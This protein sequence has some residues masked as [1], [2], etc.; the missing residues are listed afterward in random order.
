MLLFEI[1]SKLM[2]NGTWPFLLTPKL[3]QLDLI[4]TLIFIS[5]EI[6]SIVPIST[7]EKEIEIE[8]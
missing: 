7:V 6:H 3:Y 5:P 2:K 8:V 1:N 4:S